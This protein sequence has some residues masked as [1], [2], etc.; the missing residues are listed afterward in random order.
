MKISTKLYAGFTAVAVLVIFVGYVAANMSQDALE[1]STGEQS[2]VLLA[3][4]LKDMGDVLEGEIYA[5]HMFTTNPLLTESLHASNT[6]FAAMNDTEAYINAQDAAWQSTASVTPFMES[7]LVNALAVEL[8]RRLDF[9][10]QQTGHNVYGEIF[11]TNAYGANVAQTG[12]T[13]DYRQNDEVWWQEAVRDGI[14][15]QQV[16]YDESANIYSTD[17]GIRVDQDG[18]FLGVLKLVLNIERVLDIVDETQEASKYPSTRFVLL[19][20]NTKV[21]HDSKNEYAVLS[22]YPHTLPGLSYAINE[23]KLRVYEQMQHPRSVLTDL[24]WSL[25]VE[26]D[27]SEV[28]RDVQQLRRVLI[29]FTVFIMSLAVLIGLCISNS[30]SK[31]IR[32]LTE[33][34]ESISTGNLK[35]TVEKK[36]LD[37]ESEIGE[38]ARS[39]D[40]TLVSLKL[41]MHEQ[42]PFEK[43]NQ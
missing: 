16:A 28:F 7:L 11:V 17:I 33:T 18:E 24:G 35:G 15:I 2:A 10:F 30:I 39:F 26:Y 19:D 34:I 21:I 29:L 41:A 36:L 12:K 38:L 3:N 5:F 1:H 13:S 8:R 32:K 14:S 31:P 37:D 4:I 40:R 9:G 6:V 42:K 23:K 43:K 20:A 22:Q 25:L 27:T